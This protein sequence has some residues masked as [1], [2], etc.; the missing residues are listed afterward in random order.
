MSGKISIAM[1][2]FNG[3]KYLR[4]QLE[5]LYAQSRVPDEVVACDDGSTDGTVRILE[6]YRRKRGLKYSVN[7]TR[8]GVNKNFEQAIRRCTGECIAL[9]DQDDVW[10]ADKVEKLHAKLREIG[11]NGLP[12]LVTSN[13]LDIDAEGRVLHANPPVP[14][15]DSFAPTLLGRKMQ[16][17]TF[18]MDRKLADLVV[19]LPEGPGVLF[20]TYIGTVAA[21]VGNKY[22]IGEPLMHYRRH[23]TNV[24]GRQAGRRTPASA[25]QRRVLPYLQF[26]DRSRLEVLQR[27]GERFAASFREERIPLFR[28]VLE[29]AASGSLS[30][31]LRGIFSLGE[32]S[33]GEK[34]DAALAVTLSHLHRRLRRPRAR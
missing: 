4:E 10:L 9:C 26:Y 13:R 28:Q 8:L 3:E 2:T 14:D 18:M 27:V 20:D 25:L 15:N 32:L 6:E 16:G 17:C 12:S 11:R 34:A 5:S 24:F 22:D 7:E 33:F 23:A 21:M 29:I 31:R 1:A 19:P 30:V